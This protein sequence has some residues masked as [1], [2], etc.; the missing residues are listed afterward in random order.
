MTKIMEVKEVEEAKK[1]EE[2]R[3]EVAA[4]FDL[5][6]TL[7][8]GPSLERRFLRMLRY[9]RAIP[10]KNY[11]LW[12]WEALR[13][14]PRGMSAV[15]HGNKMHLRGVQS[16]D[17]CG[18]DDDAVIPG[19]KS[20]QKADGQAPTI[21]SKRECASP[22]LPVP[23]FFVDAVERV[24]RHA[25]QGHTILL[26]SGTLGLLARDAARIL[27]AELARR[28]LAVRIHVCATRL[29]EAEGSWTGRILG[30]AM[31]GEVKARAVEHIASEMKLDLTNCFAY[32]DAPNDQWFLAAV[33]N[34]SAVN[35]STALE[36][37]A[38][39]REWPVLCWKERKNLTQRTQRPQSSQRRE[40]FASGSEDE[41][42]AGARREKRNESFVSPIV[43][44]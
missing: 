42:P 20:G 15:R 26:V 22:R 28:G 31:F 33:G 4:F 30:E 44:Q 32:G 23:A 1:V 10:V 24:E 21:S 18:G 14:L 5:D 16:L 27:E 29:E 19:H 17:E 6:G 25:R 11:F 43:A 39:S 9:R 34:P 40:D 2:Q 36:R 3:G 38:R 12:L 7:V 35:P 8:A 37:F 41:A 13:L